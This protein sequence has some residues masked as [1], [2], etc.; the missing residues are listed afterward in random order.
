MAYSRTCCSIAQAIVDTGTCNKIKGGAKNLRIACVGN[1]AYSLV[2]CPA[3]TVD[4]TSSGTGGSIDWVANSA[5]PAATQVWGQDPTTYT[6]FFYYIETRS[7]TIDHQ[8]ELNYDNDTDT[9]SN[10]E[11]ITFQTNVK[12]DTVY[13]AVRDY[14]GQE[15]VFVYQER[16][17]DLWYMLGHA[18]D[19]VMTS[20]TGGTGT[21]EFVPVTFTATAD[22]A[23]DLFRQ[24]SIPNPA[25][26]ADATIDAYTTAE[27]TEYLLNLLTTF[28]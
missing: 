15:V 4:A 6:A 11:T 26:S 1:L 19:M 28:T 25:N 10:L 2:P 7:K 22:D 17:S 8:W 21:D 27:Y 24:V 3:T 5:A 14:I 13:C 16:G 9:E 12:N 18:G 20:I 23:D